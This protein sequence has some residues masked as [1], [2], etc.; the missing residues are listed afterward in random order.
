MIEFDIFLG[1]EFLVR[2]CGFEML[3]LRVVGGVF[4]AYFLRFRAR[5]YYISEIFW[6]GVFGVIFS[7]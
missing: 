5:F 3:R 4:I 1:E 2:E 6:L 7:M